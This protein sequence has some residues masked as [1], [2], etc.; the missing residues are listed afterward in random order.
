[1]WSDAMRVR[2]M[3]IGLLALALVLVACSGQPPTI[4]YVVLSPTPEGSQAPA[5]TA[6]ST[7]VAAAPT[8]SPT[9][10]VT[11]TARTL[12]PAPSATSIPASFPTPVRA[13]IQYA[14]QLFENGRM[15]WLQP[16]GQIWVLLV[17]GEGRGSWATYEDTWQE[18]EPETDPSLVP[19][20][21]D[22]LQPARGFGELWRTNSSVR[23]ALGWAVQPEV[24]YVA[25]YSYEAGG[26]INDAGTYVP[27]GGTHTIFSFRGE[28]F[29]LNEANGTWSLGG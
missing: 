19:P 6:E 21:A 1:M 27:A 5:V 7:A 26:T 3:L 20:S 15:F 10:A 22:L 13:Q 18:G 28:R 8:A 9:Q 23:D 29:R 17:D 12:A 2:I 4:I 14:E 24:G 25:D 11:T 16:I